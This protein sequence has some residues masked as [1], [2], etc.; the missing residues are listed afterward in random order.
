MNGRMGDSAD[1]ACMQLLRMARSGR[2]RGAAFGLRHRHE[3][4]QKRLGW[5]RSRVG[6]QSGK[7]AA[8][9]P[10]HRVARLFRSIQHDSI[11]SGLA[12]QGELKMVSLR[13]TASCGPSL[14]HVLRTEHHS[15][16]SEMQQAQGFPASRSGLERGWKLMDALS[17][18]PGRAIGWRRAIA[19]AATCTRGQGP[20]R[21]VR[22]AGTPRRVQRRQSTNSAK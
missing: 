5:S 16:S 10:V 2:R 18:S 20:S 7:R 3:L 8:T 11:A 13:S 14:L 6:R 21:P 1:G 4:S 12:R 22:P 9:P 19:G 17:C 15:D